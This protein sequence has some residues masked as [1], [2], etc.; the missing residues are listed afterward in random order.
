MYMFSVLGEVTVT[1][2]ASATCE[3]LRVVSGFC[4]KYGSHGWRN[5]ND[6]H[7]C[8]TSWERLKNGRDINTF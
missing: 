6:F 3:G 7:P 4:G 2:L 8:L 5:R 1:Q